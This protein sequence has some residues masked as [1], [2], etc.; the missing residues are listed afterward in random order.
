MYLSE[1]LD[2][3]SCFISDFLP[4][5]WKWC[6]LR[7]LIFGCWN[8][9][10]CS[11]CFVLSW[12]LWASCWEHWTNCS[13]DCCSIVSLTWLATSSMQE[14][15]LWPQK[16]KCRNACGVCPSVLHSCDIFITEDS[17]FGH[18]TSI[19]SSLPLPPPDKN[20]EDDD[21]VDGGRSSSSSKGA[22]LSGRKPVSMGS[23]RR[24]SSAS[25]AK[26]AGQSRRVT[27]RICIKTASGQEVARSVELYKCRVLWYLI[28]K[29]WQQAGSHIT[30][31]HN[32]IISKATVE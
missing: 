5:R 4:N 14:C 28:K 8:R 17:L 23:F 6:T 25:S 22:S 20:F 2:S 10:V 19:F 7:R 31:M 21:S 18:V 9:T 27:D 11:E 15:K 1:E 30:T 26:S 32:G 12:S 29:Q 24:P 16:W 3:P 13:V